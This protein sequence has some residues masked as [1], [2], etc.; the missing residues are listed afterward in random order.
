MI[1]TITHCQFYDK[2]AFKIIELQRC[3][4]YL[5]TLHIPTY[6][7]ARDAHLLREAI[8][9]QRQLNP[10]Q[11][12]VATYLNLPAHSAYSTCLS[13]PNPVAFVP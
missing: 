5:Y 6:N 3:P 8:A 12:R 1:Q 2:S 7:R 13:Y 4:F 9:L 11:A 10:T